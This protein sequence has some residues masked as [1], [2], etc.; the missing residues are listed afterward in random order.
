MQK[1]YDTALDSAAF[2]LGQ[3]YDTGLAQIDGY[4]AEEDIPFGSFVQTGTTSTGGNAFFVKKLAPKGRFMGVA[5]RDQAQPVGATLATASTTDSMSTIVNSFESFPKGS[6]VSVMKLGRVA[7]M[8][9]GGTIMTNAAAGATMVWDPADA[10]TM[11]FT[12]A[13]V[14]ES[15]TAYNIGTLLTAPV[16]GQLVVVQINKL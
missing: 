10:G 4:F 6:A 13:P 3:V 16:A 12:V 15:E 8:I 1:N 9:P 11:T 2:L 5:I 7:V 14:A